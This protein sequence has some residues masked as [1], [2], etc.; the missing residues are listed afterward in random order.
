[1][2]SAILVFIGAVHGQQKIDPNL[3]DGAMSSQHPGF[4]LD[5]CIFGIGSFCHTDEHSINSHP[6][7]TLVIPRSNVKSVRITNRKDCCGWRMQNMKVWVGTKFP[8]TAYAEYDRGELLGYFPGPGTDD[9]VVVIASTTGLVGTH[10][11]VQMTNSD[12]IINLQKIEVYGESASVVGYGGPN[13]WSYCTGSCSLGQG[14]CDRD[15]D[16][17]G[18]LVCGTDNCRDFNSQAYANAD[19]CI[20]PGSSK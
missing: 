13:D 18:D 1:M 11:V 9:Q 7:I 5:N 3:L 17:S 20:K 12:N 2:I 16:C 15:T 6:W 19:C 14:D 4:P 10:V 8:S